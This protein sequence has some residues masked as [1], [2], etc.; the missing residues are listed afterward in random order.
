VP[1]QGRGEVALGHGARRRVEQRQQ[2]LVVL[3]LERAVGRGHRLRRL[4]QLAFEP[5]HRRAARDETT[6]PL[7]REVRVLD[8]LGS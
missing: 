4:A 2:Q 8:D 5:V 6:D 3:T 1:A 7:G